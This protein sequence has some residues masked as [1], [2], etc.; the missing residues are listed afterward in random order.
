[1][2][3]FSK[4]YAQ[5]N[6]NSEASHKIY[7]INI[8]LKIWISETHMYVKDRK[9]TK[10]LTVFMSNEILDKEFFFFIFMGFSYNDSGLLL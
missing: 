5:Y 7:S 3:N 10:I 6:F 8:R 4:N 1:M 2:K 9:I